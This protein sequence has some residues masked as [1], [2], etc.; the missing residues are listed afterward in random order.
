ME[1]LTDREKEVLDLL[2]AGDKYSD[3][4][5]KLFLSLATVKTHVSHIYQKLNIRRRSELYVKF[6]RRKQEG[7]NRGPAVPTSN[8]LKVKS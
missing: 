5:E 3:I 2:Y 6:N 4:A 1:E 8:S 7:E